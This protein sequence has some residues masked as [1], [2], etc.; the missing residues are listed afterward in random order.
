MFGMNASE[1]SSSF[2]YAM[3]AGMI[4]SMCATAASALS[5]WLNCG[6]VRS[7]TTMGLRD[8][9]TFRSEGIAA[10]ITGVVAQMNSAGGSANG[11][12]LGVAPGKVGSSVVLDPSL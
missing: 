9:G 12:K 5:V 1:T 7:M 2:M 10:G 11:G 4:T 8:D 6:Y 3:Q